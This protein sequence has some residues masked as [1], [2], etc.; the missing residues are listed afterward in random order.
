MGLY[1][2]DVALLGMLTMDSMR[3]G[4]LVVDTGLHALG[5]SRGQA[6]DY[7][8][9]NTP[10][11]EVEI[12]AEIDR[13]ITYPGQALS[14]MVGRLEIL[15]IREAAEKALG[16]RFDIKEFHDLVLGGGALP[17]SVLDAVVAEWVAENGARE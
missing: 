9:E 1:S 16:E 17:L 13:Y 15:R 12:E 7:L 11:A 2:D 8:V 4:R 3:A 6:V 10:M 5:W 14:Y